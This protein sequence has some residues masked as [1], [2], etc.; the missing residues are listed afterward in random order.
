MAVEFRCE[1]GHLLKAREDQIGKQARCP[2]CGDV[3]TV[4]APGESL[5][6]LELLERREA[7]VPL[8]ELLQALTP[9]VVSILTP[10]SGEGAG[11]F[12]A[13]DGIVATNRHVVGTASQVTVRLADTREV[14]GKVLRAFPDVDL[15]FVK[16]NVQMQELPLAPPGA[17][18]K[19]GQSVIAI[20]NPLGFHNTVT[21]GIV[22]SVGRMVMGNQMVQTDAAI[23]PGNSGGP[24]VDLGGNVIGITTAKIGNGERLGFALPSSVVRLRLEETLQELTTGGGQVY[25]PHC[26]KTG[27]WG[28]YCGNCGAT[29]ASK[30][31]SSDRAEPQKAVTGGHCRAC[32]TSN[33]IGVKY[34]NKCGARLS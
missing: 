33:P 5:D 27:A 19:V 13:S 31:P 16:V 32:K 8:E 22:S 23:N 20:G 10:G 14:Q 18:L 21:K 11:F 9:K 24:L 2:A 6:E 25:C 3:I 26:G 7:P 29:V 28:K 34:C 4:P 30:P 17:S 1:S 12:V 15:A